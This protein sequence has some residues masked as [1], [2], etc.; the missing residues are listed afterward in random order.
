MTEGVL[1]QPFTNATK[2]GVAECN[3]LK[4]IVALT[5]F[6]E[7]DSFSFPCGAVIMKLQKRF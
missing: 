1:R 5:F 4:S 2:K 7:N 6:Y 3:P